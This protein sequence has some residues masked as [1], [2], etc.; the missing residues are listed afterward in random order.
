MTATPMRDRPIEAA[1]LLNLLLAQDEQ[2][3]MDTFMGNILKDG[4]FQS[5]QRR[6]FKDQNFAVS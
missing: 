5:D 6:E 1:S 2:L 4:E 3:S